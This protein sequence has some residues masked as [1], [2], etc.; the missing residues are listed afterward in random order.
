MTKIGWRILELA[1]SLL[2][3]TEREVVLGDLLEAGESTWQALL[4]VLG[5]LLRR[6]I[7]LWSSWKP[8][9][10]GLGLALPCGY[11]LPRVSVSISC[12]YARLALH[13]VYD[14]YYPTGHEGYAL[15]LCHVF[16]LIAWSW[17]AGYLL[18][19]VSRR[20][21]VVSAAVSMLP[22]VNLFGP[23]DFPALPAG[24]M[25]LFIVPAIWGVHHGLRKARVRFYGACLLASTVTAVM[26]VA[27]ENGALWVYNWVL[28][29]PAWYLVAKTGALGRNEQAGSRWSPDQTTFTRAS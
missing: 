14:A 17:T 7:T 18:G 29:W 2:E 27:W 13:K 20:T 9:L 6:Q 15:L 25:F 3:S 21:V 1:S 16:L 11:L 24:W 8:W 5:L 19:A 22:C 28:V 23:C 10:A 12:T 4:N 26:L